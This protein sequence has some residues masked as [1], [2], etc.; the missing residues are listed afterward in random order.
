MH[1]R[2]F[3]PHAASRR[4]LLRKCALGFGGVAFAALQSEPAKG[5]VLD[6]LAPRTPHFPTSVRNV[7]FLYMDGGPSQVDTFDYKP[8][9]EKYHGQDPR[10][11][12]G[13]LAPTQFDNI[14]K[15]LKPQWDFKQR[16]DSGHWVSGLFPHLAEKEVID[17][18]AMIKSMTSKFS[19]H[20]SANYFLHTGSGFQGRPSMGAWFG[21]GLGTEN[22]NLP[23]FVVLNGGLIPPGGLDCFGSGFLPAAY[24][25]SVFL[26]KEQPI[27]NIK[28][29]E[30]SAQLQKN[31]L[32]AIRQL[33]GETLVATGHD[34]QV[35]AAIQNYETA[36]RMQSAVPDLMDLSGESASVKEM[37][38]LNSDFK[39]TQVYGLQCLVARRLIERGVRFVEI[40]CPSGNGDR[41]DQHSRLVDG[42]S[43]NC[44]TVDQP[45]AALIKD[46][47]RT[48]LLES[49][50][51]V[52]AGE[53][54]RT[55]F[56]QGNDGRDHNPFGFT[57][58]MAG[59]GVKGG[60]SV[61]RTDDFGYKAVEDRLEIHDLHAT[62]LHLL[63]IEHTQS[64]FR[65]S[66]RDMRLTEVHGHV[67]KEI[68]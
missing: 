68:L 39:N 50:L 60:S 58:W 2:Q 24:Q 34:P 17:E 11:A 29:H 47:R 43:K 12:I 65:F 53:F 46:L 19:E 37:Y 20:T 26:P 61:G 10:K 38:G 18:I 30:P 5:A 6:P 13:R 15:V 44:K 25:G 3:Q 48:G 41:W 27:A 23:G 62:M 36:F 35:E 55:P 45:I 31:K 54:G 21:Y 7:I 59:G 9:L 63:G 51:V 56:A 57:V 40:T 67:I 32:G 64:T 33:D 28:P 52:F 4:E 8:A 14:G 42:H 22:K 16:G 1:C 66:G 49:T